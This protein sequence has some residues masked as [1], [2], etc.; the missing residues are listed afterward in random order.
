MY[1]RLC[2]WAF[3]QRLVSEILISDL[4]KRK[5]HLDDALLMVIKAIPC[6]FII[7]K[8][9]SKNFAWFWFRSGGNHSRKYWT[10][11]SKEMYFISRPLILIL[12]A[13]DAK[14]T[15]L[16]KILL[17]IGGERVPDNLC[18]AD[19]PGLK[20]HSAQSHTRITQL[21]FTIC[22]TLWANVTLRKSKGYLRRANND[23][24]NAQIMIYWLDL[25]LN[26]IVKSLSA[27]VRLGSKS[28]S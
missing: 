7:C 13:Q 28:R 10:I 20:E 23:I 27:M 11:A 5:K 9:R 1:K 22:N 21:P 24:N 2:M 26:E 25:G 14:A 15:D 16:V 4:Q 12:I 6:V 18:A 17:C 3:R 19:S 8:Q